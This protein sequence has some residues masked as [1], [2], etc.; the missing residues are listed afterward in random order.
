MPLK[1]LVNVCQLK[2]HLTLDEQISYGEYLAVHSGLRNARVAVFHPA[3]HNPNVIIDSTAFSNGYMLAQFID[4][5]EAINWL[6][7]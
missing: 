5:K 4:I 3:S 2:M 6:N 1:I 7:S